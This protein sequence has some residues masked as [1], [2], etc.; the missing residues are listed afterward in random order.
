LAGCIAGLAGGCAE[1]AV[2]AAAGVTTGF[3]LAQGQAEA[4]IRGELKAARMVPMDDAWSAVVAAMNEPQVPIQ[5]VRRGEYDAFVRGRAEGGPEIKVQVKAKSPMI[6]K[7]EI[8]I[9]MAGD[10][11]VSRL[12]MSRIDEQLGIMHPLVPVEESPFVAPMTQP[13]R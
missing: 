11:A 7:F 5:T 3:A 13:N 10:Q 1:S 12:I 4:F 6:S 8:R 9:G 2:I